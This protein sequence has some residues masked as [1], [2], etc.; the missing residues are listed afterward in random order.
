MCQATS[1]FADGKIAHMAVFPDWIG[2][3]LNG[4]G[5]IRWWISEVARY[6]EKIKFD[7][8]WIDMS[9]VSSFC[10]GSCGSENRTYT[11]G[12]SHE[13]LVLEE[14][15]EDAD[16]GSKASSTGELVRRTN[17]PKQPMRN[18]ANPPYAIDN[19]HGDL[20]GKTVSP[21]AVHHG[22]YIDYDFHNLFGHQILNATYHALLKVFPK[23]RPFIIGRSQFA[24]SAKWAGHW[25]LVQDLPS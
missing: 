10:R 23:K 6:H 20:D 15:V 4:T 16:I 5:A 17:K 21:T 3:V 7:G 9:E 25:G 13:S 1:V 22:G 11:V 18:V 19:F 14:E 2:A 8:I 24:G 12:P